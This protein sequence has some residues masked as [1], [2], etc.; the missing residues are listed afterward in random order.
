VLSPARAG[1]LLGLI[2]AG[3][4]LRLV[5]TSDVFALSTVDAPNLHWTTA[6][7]VT[8]AVATESGTNVFEIQ[9][10][11]IEARLRALPAVAAAT[12][13]VGIPGSLEVQVTERQP[14]L[15]WRVGN[16]T[17]LVDD[18][19]TLF[20]T[21]D[22][23]TLA[24]VAVPVVTADRQRERRSDSVVGDDRDCPGCEGRVV[25]GGE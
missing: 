23:A 7:A 24:S 8:A 12:V 3:L 21:V 15:A 10:A 16:S 14:I 25:D 17:Y 13:R 4:L 5:T 11:P 18:E 1:G 19:G 6:D 2:V 9:T 20:A 22:D